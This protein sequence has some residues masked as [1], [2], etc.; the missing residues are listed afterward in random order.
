MN[1]SEV[2][3]NFFNRE[4]ISDFK[5]NNVS[6]NSK[7]LNKNDIFVAIRGGNSFVNEALE[8][9]AFAVYDSEAVKIDE[10]YAERAF[11]VKDSIEFL[12]KFAREWR[13]NDSKGHDLP[14][15]F[16]KI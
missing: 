1:K 12:Q 10:K 3:Q 13:K 7:E 15:A 2:F 5:I 8:K 4:K 6:I 11:F 14:L 16:T 9:G